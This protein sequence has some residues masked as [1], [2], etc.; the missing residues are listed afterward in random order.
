M[1][2][3]HIFNNERTTDSVAWDLALV[4]ASK[5]SSLTAPEDVLRKI[6]EIYPSCREAAKARWSHENPPPENLDVLF[7]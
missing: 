5:D 3:T 6:I 1:S 2:E 7:I 4:I